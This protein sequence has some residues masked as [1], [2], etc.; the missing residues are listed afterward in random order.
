MGTDIHAVA[1][2]GIKTTYGA[3]VKTYGQ[4]REW[5]GPRG[6]DDLHDFDPK[7]GKPNYKMSSSPPP[8]LKRWQ[9]DVVGGLYEPSND[10]VCIVSYKVT[11]SPSHRLD[12]SAERVPHVL[13]VPLFIDFKVDML[14]LG[15]WSE[16]NFG[17]WLYLD[18]SC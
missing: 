3:V 17:L 8:E 16:E 7:T 10:E 4:T 11:R 2:W 5:I 1:A 6:G 12:I 18:V 14:K 9:I 13:D 15:L